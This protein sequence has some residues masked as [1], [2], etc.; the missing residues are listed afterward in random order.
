MNL[1][2]LVKVRRGQKYTAHLIKFSGESDREMF[3]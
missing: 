3:Y 2:D 1:F